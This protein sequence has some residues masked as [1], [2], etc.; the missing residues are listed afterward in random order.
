MIFCINV[1]HQYFVVQAK[2]IIVREKHILYRK[3]WCTQYFCESRIR[4]KPNILC[5][6]NIVLNPDL[7][8]KSTSVNT[9]S[10]DLKPKFSCKSTSVYV[11][12]L[13]QFLPTPIFPL[14]CTVLALL[15]CTIKALCMLDFCPFDIC[16]IPF[17]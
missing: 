10:S 9:I 15:L 5:E 14:Y 11:Y 17:A 12:H 3:N 6:H 1:V 8:W 16:C 2:I 7:R 4:V 13:N